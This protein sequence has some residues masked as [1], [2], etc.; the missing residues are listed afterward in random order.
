MAG[1]WTDLKIRVNFALQLSNSERPLT[2]N[3]PPIDSV[4]H[5]AS[6][7]S[8]EVQ[9]GLNI[10]GVVAAAADAHSRTTIDEAPLPEQAAAGSAAES[11]PPTK[12]TE[13][14]VPL[15]IHLSRRR[16]HEAPY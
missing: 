14:R 8:A 4:L 15:R 10:P 6:A 16:G 2:L 3:L 9:E 7:S 1:E 5:T 12:C 13:Q 11:K